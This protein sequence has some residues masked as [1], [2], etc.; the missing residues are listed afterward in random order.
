MPRPPLSPP[1]F[2]TADSAPSA[3]AKARSARNLTRL[4]AIPG[5]PFF[6]PEALIDRRPDLPE[7][8]LAALTPGGARTCFGELAVGERQRAL[9]LEHLV[10]RLLLVGFLGF[11]V[12]QGLLLVL[13]RGRQALLRRGIAVVS[14]LHL[15]RSASTTTGAHTCAAA[16]AARAGR[17][18]ATT[19]ATTARAVAQR[20]RAASTSGAVGVEPRQRQV[21]VLVELRIIG[22]LG[23][24]NPAKRRDW[25]HRTR[26][27][28]RRAVWPPCDRRPGR[29]CASRFAACRVRRCPG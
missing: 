17:S 28:C 14:R 6:D 15:C 8:T 25:S 26:S 12:G 16:E 1:H 18:A 22:A 11:R 10:V 20:R 19:E 24:R 27:A 9:G 23:A 7:V 21:G 29:R 2:V 13:P 3:G 5:S 4:S